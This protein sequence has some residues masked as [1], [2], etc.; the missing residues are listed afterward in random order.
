MAR[1]SADAP[2]LSTAASRSRYEEARGRRIQYLLTMGL[3]V[4]CFIVAVAVPVPVVRIVAL[5][6]ACVL[7]YVAVV[8]ANTVRRVTPS[9]VPAYYL[10]AQDRQLTA[11]VGAGEPGQDG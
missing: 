5:V 3:R 7:P 6:G 2:V 4:A 11:G 1:R 10:P 9:G 8:G